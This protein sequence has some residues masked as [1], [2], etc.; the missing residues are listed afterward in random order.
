[1]RRKW[2]WLPRLRG[3]NAFQDMLVYGFYGFSADHRQHMGRERGE[4]ATGFPVSLEL[5]LPCTETALHGVRDRQPAFVTLPALLALRDRIKPVSQGASCL[6]GGLPSFGDGNVRKSPQPHFPPST[7]DHQT[8]H[9]P[10][11]FLLG[12]YQPQS[13]TVRVFPLAEVLGLEVCEDVTFGHMLSTFLSTLIGGYG[14]I[15]VVSD[16]KVLCGISL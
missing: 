1:M 7:V 14:Y 5:G 15:S 11:G 12:L 10:A 9:P 3:E 2:L 13:L 6:G 16:G 4:P 8:K